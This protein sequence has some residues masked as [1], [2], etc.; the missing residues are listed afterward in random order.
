MKE[1][2]ASVWNKVKEVDV[3]QDNLKKVR[4]KKNQK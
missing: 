4:V 1:C 3:K 2:K